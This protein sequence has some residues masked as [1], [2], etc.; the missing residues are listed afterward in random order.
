MKTRLLICALLALF[1]VS[2]P[3]FG[4]DSP[5]R[6]AAGNDGT[7]TKL[8]YFRAGQWLP[9]DMRMDVFSGPA[10]LAGGARV[11][12]HRIEAGKP[13]FSGTLNGIDYTMEYRTVATGVDI[14]VT[15]R[16]R[17]N[18]K[19]APEALTL[20]LGIDTQMNQYPAW[21]H[22]FFPTCQR[23]EPEYYWGYLMNPDGAILTMASDSP[24]AS[25][26]TTYDPTTSVDLLHAL[27]LPARHPQNLYALA[28]G[29]SR[30]WTLH[31]STVAELKDVPASIEKLSG[32]PCTSLDRYTVAPGE[33]VVATAKGK[34]TAVDTSGMAIGLHPVGTALLVVRHPWS[35]YL[36]KARENAVSKPQKGSSHMESWLGLYSG[37]FARI[38]FP[39]AALDKAIDDKF[40]EIFPLMYNTELK[41]KEGRIQNDAAM[42]GLLAARYEATGD[43]QSLERASRMCD[44]LIAYQAAEGPKSGAYINGKTHYTCVAYLAKYLME[45]MAWEKKLAAT[46]PEWKARWE[47]HLD[48]VRK[49][50]DEL[51]LHLDNIETEGTVM[52][53]D[54]MIACSYMQIAMFA[55]D[56]AAPAEREKYIEAA[57]TMRL[58]HQCLSQIVVPDA[59]MNGGSLRYWESQFD[60]LMRPSMM[61]SPH[62]WSA[63]RLYGL[64]YLYELTGDEELLR[65]AMNGLG[66]CCQLIDFDTGELRWA[67]VR[68]PYVRATAFAQTADTKGKGEFVP[69]II[70]EQ[71]VP[72]I[73]GWYR[74]KPNT[75]VTGYWGVEKDKSE[76]GCCD[77]DVHE[78]F[79]CLAEF[80][81]DKAYVIVRGDGTIG[82][83]NCT[84]TWE[85]GVVTV[86]PAEDCVTRVHV[87][88][89]K[90]SNVTVRFSK[91]EKKATISQPRWIE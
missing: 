56:Y 63:W 55:R 62:G 35:W 19:F 18:G 49:A 77:N 1:A 54:G 52:Y 85:N 40:H 16:N 3:A 48:S 67:F 28:S 59:R 50:I 26:H 10:I 68:D 51:V 2:F 73:S 82:C 44:G 25:W 84:S 61:D 41:P 39:D 81:L 45:V 9:V 33:T 88:A 4:Q 46:S 7:L 66:A 11:V 32:K 60:V 20:Q 91:G 5:L 53:E 71:Y 23:C 29:E 21:R 31:L 22:K 74:A 79:K 86:I 69:T 14:A 72:M 80:A 87:N 34:K 89:R 90:Q 42:A 13:A 38:H 70:G 64:F 6:M 76:G 37:Y 30:A 58:G 43:V 8:E 57:Q 27:P 65:Q 12:L 47:R 36:Q 17:A 83:W 24:V 15:A 78:V 75:W